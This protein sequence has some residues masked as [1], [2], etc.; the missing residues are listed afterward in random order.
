MP[1][2]LLCLCLLAAARAA[3]VT[4]V[5]EPDEG[6]LARSMPIRQMAMETPQFRNLHGSAL[7]EHDGA[8]EGA[9]RCR[10][11]K[12]NYT[13]T[14]YVA[15]DE[16]AE[17]CV[18]AT[19]LLQETSARARVIN[20]VQT[21]VAV[22]GVRK[23]EN[24]IVIFC[25]SASP[26]LQLSLPN[27]T[28]ISVRCQAPDILYRAPVVGLVPA[29]SQAVRA[30]VRDSKAAN[31]SDAAEA[32][33]TAQ[34][35]SMMGEE[36]ARFMPSIFDYVPALLEH[37]MEGP[38]LLQLTT[39]PPLPLPT[40]S[41]SEADLDRLR[42]TA[43]NGGR[44]NTWSIVKVSSY[45]AS[46]LIGAAGTVA[47]ITSA[48]LSAG[49]AGPLGVAVIGA[50]AIIDMLIPN[51]QSQAILEIQKNLIK[52]VETMSQVIEA[53]VGI[54][55]RR[56]QMN[57]HLLTFVGGLDQRLELTNT[58]ANANREDIKRLSATLE[59]FSSARTASFSRLEDDLNQV[60][61]QT[62]ELARTVAEMA[63]ES[64]DMFDEVFKVRARRAATR[65]PLAFAA[66]RS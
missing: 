58:I 7:L 1:R 63:Q 22:N 42:A 10:V 8:A 5:V 33:D 54:E 15:A 12:G 34:T 17:R 2:P 26:T 53:I 27:N 52:V 18:D 55:R 3:I 47:L 38:Q 13:V 35:L 57:E 64:R 61:G 48:G 51:Q 16:A 29:A 24:R 60:T 14:D 28:Q 31:L 6:S 50:V 43:N 65:V 49:I 62:A 32:E 25:S 44:W 19:G 41:L 66:P 11:R 45:G 30:R 56:I 40:T 59:T 21:T 36:T 9:V 39:P 4:T 20:Q 37:R 23:I 46:T